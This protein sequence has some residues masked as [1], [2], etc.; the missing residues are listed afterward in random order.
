MPHPTHA[1]PSGCVRCFSVPLVHN[2]LLQTPWLGAVYIC[3]ST[4]DRVSGVA[5]LALSQ[6]PTAL[7]SGVSL[8]LVS[9][10]GVLSQLKHHW[11]K[12]FHGGS[13]THGGF[14]DRRLGRPYSLGSLIS[15]PS[16]IDPPASQTPAGWS[17]FRAAP[18]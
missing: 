3:H 9:E 8:D 5:S 16:S 17:P 14:W 13:S 12:P 11:Q 4:A 10:N 15:R 1:V 2:K 18:D 7:Q 6:S